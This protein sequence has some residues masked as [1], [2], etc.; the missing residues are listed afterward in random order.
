MI[1]KIT[2]IIACCLVSVLILGFILTRKETPVQTESPS[3]SLA[4]D[5]ISAGDKGFNTVLNATE[6]TVV[7]TPI[8]ISSTK[9]F[10]MPDLTKILYERLNPSQSFIQDIQLALL[11]YGDE[12]LDAK[13]DHITIIP[14]SLSI[15]NNI[16]SGKI[17]A[18]ELP[19]T[20]T[21]SIQPMG[22][23]QHAFLKTSESQGNNYTY[24]GGL[25]NLSE[26]Q[27]STLAHNAKQDR[28]VITASH[29]EAAINY[30][31]SLGYSIPELDITFTNQRGSL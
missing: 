28:I 12:F 7:A 25:Y 10:G 18:G 24:S 2:L 13:Y 11:S 3:I 17:R 15:K 8:K 5:G 4:N 1:K 9:I 23:R 22:G 19:S 26:P 14:A 20:T 29:S 27:F 16:L 21:F 31:S 6:T 30:I